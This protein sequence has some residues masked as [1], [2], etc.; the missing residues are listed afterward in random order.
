METKK[1]R[2]GRRPVFVDTGERRYV[3]P[4]SSKF[5][6]R[7]VGAMILFGVK[8]LGPLGSARQTLAGFCR[9]FVTPVALDTKSWAFNNVVMFLFCCQSAFRTVDVFG[10]EVKLVFA[11]LLVVNVEKFKSCIF[12]FRNNRR[13]EYQMKVVSLYVEQLGSTLPTSHT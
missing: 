12:L 7:S 4:T 1:A 13:E 9:V 6:P 5:W 2:G 3:A 10:E 8:G 11:M